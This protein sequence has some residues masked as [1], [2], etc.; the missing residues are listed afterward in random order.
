MFVEETYVDYMNMDGESRQ[1]VEI[2]RNFSFSS[3]LEGAWILGD[4]NVSCPFCLQIASSSQVTEYVQ[5]FN[6]NF[7]ILYI[8]IYRFPALPDFLS[9]SG[10]GTGYTQP[11]EPREVN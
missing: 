10:S 8:S 4:S 5:F 6:F 7:F 3:S 9:G 2:S 11:R 1:D